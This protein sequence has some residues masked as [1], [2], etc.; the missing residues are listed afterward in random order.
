MSRC[1]SS[2]V[3]PDLRRASSCDGAP[4]RYALDA[5]YQRVAPDVILG[6]SPLRL[7]RLTAAGR[8]VADA[9]EQA[10]T[11]PDR[12]A[13]LDRPADR[14][15]R[16]PPGPTGRRPQAVTVVV[17]T[18][19]RDA[20]PSPR[21][22]SV[23]VDDASP[24]PIEVPGATVIRLPRNGGP[25]AARNA[26]LATVTTPLVAFVDADVEL[27]DRLARPAA[28]PLRRRARRPRRA[29]G[30][31]RA[32]RVRSGRRVRGA[33]RLA[34]P[35]P[36]ARPCRRGQPRVVRARGGDRLPHRGHPGGRRV[37]RG[38]QVRRGRRPRLAAGRGRMA[39]P[40]RAGGGGRARGPPVAGRLAPPAVRL[41]HERRAA[42]A[43]PSRC[44]GPTAGQRVERG[45]VGPR[46]HPPPVRRHDADRRHGRGPATQAARRAP[47]DHG[48][49]RRRRHVRRR[50][51]DRQ[52]DQPGVVAARH[53][54][55]CL[56]A[57]PPRRRCRADR[58][59]G[60]GGLA[61]PVG[62]VR[63]DAPRRATWRTAPACGGG[64]CA[65]ARS[66]SCAPI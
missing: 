28:R 13:A 42:G 44:A 48:S 41:R 27:P 14:C 58:P 47:G 40:L 19:G 55:R 38:A 18:F 36:A 10:T 29:A 50:G 56:A 21:R 16:D 35:R 23:V 22:A 62:A 15:R 31:H 24:H 66:P 60:A 51:A 32:G 53:R 52:R 61:G 54:R 59:I 12:H 5:S 3:H 64:R 33:A 11:L 1:V 17:P 34:R 46:R 26:G 63:S 4:M 49:P 20:P 39:V 65:S 37:R 6:G 25:A 30:A 8:R 2:L 9:L 7:F 43:A 45:R 57:R